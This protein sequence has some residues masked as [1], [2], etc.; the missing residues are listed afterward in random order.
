MR[1]GDIDGR[2]LVYRVIIKQDS[3]G[4]TKNY[5]GD[6]LFENGEKL[7]AVFP[8][9]RIGLSSKVKKQGVHLF[10][11]STGSY[12]QFFDYEGTG[13][14]YITD[15]R[16]VFLRRPDIA[17]IRRAHGQ[18]NYLGPASRVL[19]ILSANALEYCEVRLEDISVFKPLLSGSNLNIVARGQR[20]KLRIGK[21]ETRV[22][23]GVLAQRRHR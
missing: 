1:V 6:L 3:R 17:S 15:K 18:D 19:P 21:E 12:V 23:R 20:Y 22:L 13:S 9:I 10:P 5:A 4:L 7:S 11:S 14:L 16:I 2:D 8:D